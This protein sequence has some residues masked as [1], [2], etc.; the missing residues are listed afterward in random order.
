[1]IRFI[2]NNDTINRAYKIAIGDLYANIGE[3]DVFGETKPVICAG[4]DYN[5]P[6]TRDAA[7]NT[8]NAG[9]FLMPDIVKNTLLSICEKQGEEYY[10]GDGG[11]YWDKIIWVLAARYYTQLIKDEEFETFVFDVSLRTLKCM[12]AEFNEEKGLF[13]GAAVYGDGISAYPDCYAL[14]IKNS[15][16]I[17]TWLQDNPEKKA[18]NGMGLPMMALSTNCVYYQVYKTIGAWA[19]E[20]GL[21]GSSYFQRAEKLKEQINLHFWND[22]KGLY[23]YLAGE[24]DAQEG[25]GLAFSIL[26]GLSD[27][28]KTQRI[29]KNITIT[30]QGIACVYPTFDRYAKLNE[31]GRHSGTIWPMIQGF[32]GLS[33]LYAKE[34]ARFDFELMSMAEKASHDLHF[35]EIYH[36]IDGNPYGGMQ[37]CYDPNGFSSFMKM[38][39]SGEKQTWSATA[40]LALIY[41]GVLGLKIEND[42]L[43]VRPHLPEYIDCAKLNGLKIGNLELDFE[44]NRESKVH[45]FSISLNEKG[46]RTIQIGSK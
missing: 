1:M 23:D 22:K 26:F 20:R 44:I 8:I 9:M 16:G 4:F 6:W 11:Q 29:A 37:E 36:P 18:K 41:Y 17:I 7:I 43:Y 19:N 24:S 35:S 15:S 40:F 12:E 39:A 2:T 27:A 25:L 14:D 46:K 30:P 34:Y 33:I 10:I 45:E 42:C 31:I 13:R 21:D 32:Y 38:W 5:T 28:E 3:A